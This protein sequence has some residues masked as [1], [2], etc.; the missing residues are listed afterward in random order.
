[1]KIEAI[2]FDLGRVLVEV[3]FAST[4]PE[5]IVEQLNQFEK[6]LYDYKC[7]LCNNLFPTKVL[8]FN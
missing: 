8:Q 5:I 4:L 7:S 2:I 3:D 1:M 6:I